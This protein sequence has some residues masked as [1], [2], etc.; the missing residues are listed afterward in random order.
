[1]INEGCINTYGTHKYFLAM[2]IILELFHGL[3]AKSITFLKYLLSNSKPIAYRI[4]EIIIKTEL[5]IT[6]FLN[7]IAAGVRKKIP[8]GDAQC[9]NKNLL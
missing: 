3:R 8:L 4:L 9:Q 5:K 1:M 2:M 7:F 6:I